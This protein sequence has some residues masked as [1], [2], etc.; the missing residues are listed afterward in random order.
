MISD[1]ADLLSFSLSNKLGFF[2]K[3]V[4]NSITLIVSDILA[5]KINFAISQSII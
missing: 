4:K 3:F 1:F 5:F 2:F